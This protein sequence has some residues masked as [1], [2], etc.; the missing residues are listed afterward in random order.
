MLITAVDVVDQPS[1]RPQLGP[2]MNKVQE[3][4]GHRTQMTLADAGYDSGNNLDEYARRGR[5]VAMP[6]SQD[7]ALENPHHEYSF[8][9][10]EASDGYRC[11]EGQLQRFTRIKHTRNT[12]MRLYRASWSV[13]RTSDMGAPRR[14]VPTTLHC[15]ATGPGCRPN[16]P[17]GRTGG[18]CNWS[19]RPSGSSK[20][21]SKPTDPW[22]AAYPT[23]RLGGDC[24][25]QPL[26][27][28][29][30]AGQARHDH[31]DKASVS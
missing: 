5:Q 15:A 1:D 27:A 18:E 3:T 29:S 17:N 26:P 6:E 28:H 11:P 4:L 30:V 8:A 12:M 7:R 19:N 23:S 9:Y 22:C 25:P 31:M 16:K 14:P 2:M 21:S 24:S 13:R 20:S 10:E